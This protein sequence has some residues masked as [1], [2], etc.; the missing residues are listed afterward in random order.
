MKV[1]E[2]EDIVGV[3]SVVDIELRGNILLKKLDFAS[4][5]LLRY[6]G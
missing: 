5:Q 1:I 3:S 2:M 4:G 6:I